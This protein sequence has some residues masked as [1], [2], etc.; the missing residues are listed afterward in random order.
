MFS[1]YPNIYNSWVVPPSLAL[2]SLL[3]PLY[4]PF[5]F[6]IPSPYFFHPPPL[7]FTPLL[8]PSPFQLTKLLHPPSFQLTK[9]LH[10]P[11]F[12]FTQ[13]LNPPSSFT[14]PILLLNLTHSPILLCNFSLFTPLMHT[15]LCSTHHIHCLFITLTKEAQIYSTKDKIKLQGLAG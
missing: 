13:L 4:S 9:L 2:S 1:I 14:H 5:V 15:Q 7:Q 11:P 12:Q 3:T 10:P 6:H 8:T